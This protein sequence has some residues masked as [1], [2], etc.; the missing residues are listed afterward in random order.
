MIPLLCVK[1]INLVRT[2]AGD[3]E[4]VYAGGMKFENI[5]LFVKPDSEA[6]K[7]AQKVTAFLTEQGLRIHHINGAVPKV[8]KALALVLGGDGSMLTAA[9]A[10]YGKDVPV[11]GINLGHLGFLTEL[12][13]DGDLHRHLLAL[14][15]PKATTEQR[16]Y[17]TCTLVDEEK[18]QKQWHFVND[19]TL[20]RQPDEKM[21]NMS[22]KIRDRHITTSRADGMIIST[23][24]GST[25]YNL[26]AGGPLLHPDIDAMVITPI[27]PHTL[28]LRPVVVPPCCIEINLESPDPAQLSLDG[29]TSYP[30]NKG[31]TLLVEKSKE[32]VTLRYAEKYSFFNVLQQKMNWD[33]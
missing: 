18:R 2:V 30:F 5:L 13:R 20:L 25:A 32:H 27:C 4:I 31:Q 17:Y 19:L 7:T 14:L 28:T 21:L 1:H 29:R 24:T 9:A 33:S 23:P 26:S 12:E 22:L 6:E 8:E 11:A 16:P 15:N 3:A 10:L